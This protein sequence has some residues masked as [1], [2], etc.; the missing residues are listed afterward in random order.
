MNEVTAFIF[1]NNLNGR[2]KKLLDVKQNLKGAQFNREEK[3][4]TLELESFGK[5]RKVSKSLG[6]LQIKKKIEKV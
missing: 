4:N 5:F 3:K 6:R 2:L 1:M